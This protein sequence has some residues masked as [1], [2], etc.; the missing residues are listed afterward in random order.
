MYLR[1]QIESFGLFSALR[2]EP[3]ELKGPVVLVDESGRVAE[4]NS[5]AQA[6][7]LIPGMT[8]ARALARCSGVEVVH[9]DPAAA[10]AAERILWNAAWQITP[11]IELGAGAQAGVATLELVRPDLE[12]VN[13]QALQALQALRRCG[14]PGRAGLA[15]TPDWAGFAALTAERYQLKILPS[16]ER[17]R[18][19]LGHLP[20]TVMDGL[21][22]THCR[23]LEGWGI[24]SLAALADLPRQSLGE[25]LGAPGLAAWDVLNGKRQRVLQFSELTPDFSQKLDLESPVRDLE[26]ICF[27]VNQSAEALERQLTRQGKSARAVSIELR[28]ESKVIHRKAIRLPEATSRAALLERLLR[29]YLEPLRLDSGVCELRMA[30]DPVDPLSRQAGLF[31]RSVRNPWRLQETLDQLAGLVG[32]ESF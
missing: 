5:A 11:Q 6:R 14:L 19:L 10:H 4:L 25:R 3:R 8:M 22:A 27:L 12:Q 17:V 29:N 28:L 18:E 23:I 13:R 2:R 20:L 26:A 24:R 32:S 30:V 15:A 16:A 31:E 1:F 9:A 21:S 7:Q